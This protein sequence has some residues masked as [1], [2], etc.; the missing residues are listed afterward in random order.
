[1][2]GTG[3]AVYGADAVFTGTLLDGTGVPLPGVPVQVQK[4]GVAAFVTVGRAVTGDDGG[5]IARVPWR[6]SGTVR[7]RAVPPGAATPVS[8]GALTVAV[9]PLLEVGR[10]PPRVLAGR[11]VRVRGQVRPIG[12]VRVL[13]ERQGKDGRW[14]EVADVRMPLKGARFSKAIRLRAPGLYRLTPRTGTGRRAFQAPQVYVRAVRSLRDVRAAGDGRAGGATTT[15]PA[16][17]PGRG[18]GTGG[19]SAG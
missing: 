14:R 8:S 7:A 17:L 3:E 2:A 12:P 18:P 1:V 16:S 6:R 9:R 10:M 5:W 15:A 19:A 4:Q 13:V 11:S